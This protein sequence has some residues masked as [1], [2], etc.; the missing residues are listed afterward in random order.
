MEILHINNLDMPECLSTRFAKHD[1]DLK[2]TTFHYNHEQE[3]VLVGVSN[4]VIVMWSKKSD[5]SSD[6]LY[7]SET[8]ISIRLNSEEKKHKGA[9]VSLS[10]ECINNDWYILSSSVDSTLKIWDIAERNEERFKPI[11]TLVGH[12]GTVVSFKYLVETDY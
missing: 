8:L 11:Q 1:K 2:I 4:G 7:H 10:L 9:I 6:K 5:R 3:L 12:S